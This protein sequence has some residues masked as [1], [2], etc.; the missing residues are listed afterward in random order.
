MP[1]LNQEIDRTG[2]GSIKWEYLYKDKELVFGD[3]THK[4]HGRERILPLWVADMDFPVPEAVT[5]AIIHRAQ[6]PVFGYTFPSDNYFE[7]VINWIERRNNWKIE[8]DWITLTPGVVSAFNFAVKAFSEPGDKILIQRP[9]YYPFMMAAEENGRE[10]VSN[11]LVYDSGRFHIDFADLTKKAADPAVKL[12]ILCSPHNPVSRVWTP[13][14]L[15]KLGEI[16]LE[17]DVLV[18]SD[19]IHCDLIFS[20]HTFTPFASLSEDFAQNSIICTAASKTFNLAGLANSNIIIPNK[21]LRESF[22][23]ELGSGGLWGT[24]IFGMV[25]TEAALTHGEPWLT[26]VM[27]YI[28]GNYHFMKAYLAEHIPQIKLIEPEGTYLIWADCSA[29][30][31]DAVTRRQLL[32]DDAK[33]FLDEGVHFGPEG[34]QFE[35][36]NVACPRD[37]LAEALE[38][39]RGVISQTG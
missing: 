33:V 35:R 30:E 20:G 27:A 23:K 32:L 29:L 26:E 12:L 3:H 4:K 13:E 14:E 38:R 37:V 2:T 7:A 16:C 1:D 17:N 28:E 31:L 15:T 36:I 39:M 19:E 34:E 11:S 21:D 9:V 18:V 6:H 22:R 24:N 8:R 25:G 5:K 10:L